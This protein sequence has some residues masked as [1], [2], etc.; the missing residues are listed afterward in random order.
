MPFTTIDAA[1]L[2]DLGV[3]EAAFDFYTNGNMSI[4]NL[5]PSKKYTLTFFGS[6]QYNGGSDIN[7]NTTNY[8]AYTDNTFTTSV[9]STSLVIGGDGF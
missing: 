5:D 1:A 6:H 3:K 7:L 4:D 9:A 8:T 2:G